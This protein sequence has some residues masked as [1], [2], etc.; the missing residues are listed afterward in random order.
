M[1]QILRKRTEENKIYNIKEF[2]IATQS[3][4]EIINDVNSIWETKMEKTTSI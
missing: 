2:M 4:I 3:C 1:P